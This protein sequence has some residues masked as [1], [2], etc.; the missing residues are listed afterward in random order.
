MSLYTSDFV[1]PLRIQCSL[2]RRLCS[3][4]PLFALTF[5]RAA[6]IF[7]TQR[8]ASGDSI[9][10]QGTDQLPP[11]PALCGVSTAK[12][13]ACAP[14]RYR[15]YCTNS[16]WRCVNSSVRL[17]VIE[18]ATLGLYCGSRRWRCR[19]HTAP[20]GLDTKRSSIAC[21]KLPFWHSRRVDS[22]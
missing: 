8:A 15:P 6:S 5:L 12:F 18:T 7:L 14:H 2:C 19:W 21:S 4:S 20:C 1:L 9:L 11:A 3:V 17:G 16:M 13:Q 22:S 10:S